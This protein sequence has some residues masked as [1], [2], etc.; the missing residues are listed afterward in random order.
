[1]GTYILH[2]KQRP[3]QQHL[4]AP[5][6]MTRP[7][8]K[9]LDHFEPLQSTDC[10]R[11]FFTIL[12]ASDALLQVTQFA[13]PNQ[14]TPVQSTHSQGLNL[15]MSLLPGLGKVEA[16]IWKRSIGNLIFLHDIPVDVARYLPP[17]KGRAAHPT[18]AYRIDA[19]PLPPFLSELPGVDHGRTAP[20]LSNTSFDDLAV[21]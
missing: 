14:T 9:R 15:V 12:L 17:V 19:S 10:P 13:G 6:L 18:R 5:G 7:D 4:S 11:N 21:V 20:A 16:A 1:M 3:W 2:Q 8:S